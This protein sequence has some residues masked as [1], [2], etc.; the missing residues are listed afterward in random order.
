MYRK[1]GVSVHFLIV[2]V[3]I[4]LG[5]MSACS[6]ESRLEKLIIARSKDINKQCPMMV[7][8]ATRLDVTVAA[9][10]VLIYKYTLVGTAVAE[11][12]TSYFH[13]EVKR[14]TTTSYCTMTNMRQM[15]KDGIRCRYMY[16]DKNGAFVTNFLITKESCED[17]DRR[18]ELE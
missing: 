16:F 13:E 14:R 5:A 17:Y 6:G 9:G 2:F 4:V 3:V 11:M 7:D 8:S 10:D 12:D 1:V 15:L 18:E